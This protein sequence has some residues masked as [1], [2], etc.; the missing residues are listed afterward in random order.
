MKIKSYS[1]FV[2]I[3]RS[4]NAYWDY[5]KYR[6]IFNKWYENE[7]V[8]GD[9]KTPFWWNSERF[10]CSECHIN[11][12]GI[13]QIVEHIMSNHFVLVKIIPEVSMVFK[14][15]VKVISKAPEVE[16][17]LIKKHRF[18]HPLKP[19]QDPES[20]FCSPKLKQIIGKEPQGKECQ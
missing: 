8:C 9:D 2:K 7:M 14:K 18:R 19:W 4:A 10:V 16:N 11:I 17:K 6:N 5:I 20:L 12:R 15:K 1:K 13:T 3:I